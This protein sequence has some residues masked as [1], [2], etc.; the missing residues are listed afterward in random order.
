MS[1]KVAVRLRTDPEADLSLQLLG[2][3]RPPPISRV[4]FRSAAKIAA[5]KGPN[6][7]FLSYNHEEIKETEILIRNSEVIEIL[8]R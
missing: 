6:C 2:A 5:L 4:E 8:Q 7:L 1:I 3:P